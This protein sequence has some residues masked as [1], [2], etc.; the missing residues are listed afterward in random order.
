MAEALRLGQAPAAP[1]TPVAPPSNGGLPTDQTWMTQPNAAA[2]QVFRQVF[3]PQVQQYIG[4]QAGLIRNAMESKY[5][6][7]FQKYGPEIDSVLARV[8]VENR[9]L[10]IV[11]HAVKLVRGNHVD[12][13][14][15]ERAKQK[16]AQMGGMTE[17]ADGS[18]AGGPG[19]TSSTVDLT[20]LPNGLADMAKREGLTIQQVQDSCK[21]MGMTTENWMKMAQ[22]QKLFSSTGK[23]G[24]EMGESAEGMGGERKFS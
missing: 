21:A 5:P 6:D 22:E 24:F 7:M 20:K 11:E 4:N 18:G 12:E 8:P 13:I 9:T 23:F 15:D 3:A 17:R 2:E 14:A 1:P 19:V 16:M 10:D